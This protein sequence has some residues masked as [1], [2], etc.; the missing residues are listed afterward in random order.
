V[1]INTFGLN[2]TAVNAPHRA[3]PNVTTRRAA[4]STARLWS[5]ADGVRP[6]RLA[7]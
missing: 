3:Y 6:T 1:G 5:S 4:A 2:F 7:T